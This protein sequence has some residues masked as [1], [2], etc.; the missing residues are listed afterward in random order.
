M[1]LQEIFEQLSSTELN[2]VSIGGA[3]QGV[4]D[5]S[6]WHLLV[7]HINL[8]L[9]NLYQRFLL[10]EASEVINLVSGTTVYTVQAADFVKLHKVRTEAGTELALN[11]KF[12]AWA[13][14]TPE[15]RTLVVPE[16]I[17][18]RSVDL[19]VELQTSSLEVVYR[20]THP[21]ITVTSS[22]FNPATYEVGLPYQFLQ[23]LLCFIASR[24]FSP[25]GQG[26]ENSLGIMYATRFE[27][28][29]RRLE[30]DGVALSSGEGQR[31]F[32]ERGFV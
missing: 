28:E 10:K 17:V 13:I 25:V 18:N 31:M 8:G 22:G 11:D 12:N 5:A 4:I 3:N 7:G 2:Q 29:C 30:T 16:V 14:Q 32:L 9:A 24:I 1:K 20:A 26:S 15:L 6:N 27:Q 21:K 23:A 19:P